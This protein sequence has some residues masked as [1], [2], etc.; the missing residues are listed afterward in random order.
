MPDSCAGVSFTVAMACGRIV[1]GS[2]GFVMPDSCAGV[3]FTVAM[4]LSCQIAV[5]AYRL[6]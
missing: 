2:Y 3:L 1:D 4:A 5:R 6:Q